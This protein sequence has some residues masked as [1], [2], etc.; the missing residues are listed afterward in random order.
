MV[1]TKVNLSLFLTGFG[2]FRHGVD[3]AVSNVSN[4]I[5]NASAAVQNYRR[6]IQLVQAGCSYPETS[7]ET[8]FAT[9]IASG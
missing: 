8:R 1:N 5:D 3:D 4:A 6:R 2:L 7:V 9:A